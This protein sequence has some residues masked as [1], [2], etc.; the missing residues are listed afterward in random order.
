MDFN[1][2][3]PQSGRYN[4]IMVVVDKLSLYAHIVGLTHP[5][6][7]STVASAFMD[8][9]HK[10]HSMPESII[11]DR[12]KIFTSHFWQQMVALTGT[13][14]R[15][16]SSYHP[17]NDG[18]TERVNQC[19][20]AF[21]RCFTHACPLKWAQWLA[22][23]E[24]WYN[25]SMYSALDGKPMFQVLYGHSPRHFGLTPE[26]ATPITDLEVWL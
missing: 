24:Y 1:E 18:Q 4:Y 5:F 26:D 10:L 2:G 13:Q 15:M 25:T 16:S 3:L 14:L 20:E 6:T 11:S 22:L 12:D 19:V 21:L 9:I 8:N 7:A 17:Q 23:A